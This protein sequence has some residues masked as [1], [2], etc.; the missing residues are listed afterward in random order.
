MIVHPLPVFS[1]SVLLFSLPPLVRNNP[2]LII[3]MVATIISLVLLSIAMLSIARRDQALKLS[4]NR[5]RSL[6]SSMSEGVSLQKFVYDESGRAVRSLITTST[7]PH[8]PAN[9]PS[10]PGRLGARTSSPRTRVPLLPINFR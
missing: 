7:P 2:Y 5:Y 8:S 1:W 3:A 6:Y 4:E 9:S 10:G